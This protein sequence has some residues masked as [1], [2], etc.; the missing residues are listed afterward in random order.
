MDTPL[1]IVNHQ[2][3]V[4]PYEQISL[5]V[6]RLIAEKAMPPGM[7]LPPVRQ[8][9]ED[10]GVAPNTVIRA[11]DEL[12]RDGWVVRTARKNVA[13]VSQ[14]PQLREVGRDRLAHAVSDLLEVV[15]LLNASPEE[16]HGE[17]DRQI[18]LSESA[19]VP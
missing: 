17:I 6:R 7:L 10:L 5:Q 9:A 2:S 16:V 11:Y 3:T 19:H 4:L 13:V 14:P 18:H 8:L 1:L 12:E 15:R